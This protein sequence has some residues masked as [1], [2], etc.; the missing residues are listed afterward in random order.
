MNIG[1]IWAQATGGAI[2]RNGQ[3]PWHLP[4][5]LAHFKQSTL[6]HPVIMGRKTWESLPPSFRPLPGRLNIVVTRNSDAVAAGATVVSSLEDARDLAQQNAAEWAWVIGG[7]QLYV[8]AMPIADELLVTHIDLKVSDADTFAPPIDD[9]FEL[10][11]STKS[12][13]SQT[14]LNYHFERWR[15]RHGNLDR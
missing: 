7:G 9:A 14:G 2:G 3:M 4:E 15:R 6:G 12:L 1:L 13:T 8:Q 11:H 5:D 10:V